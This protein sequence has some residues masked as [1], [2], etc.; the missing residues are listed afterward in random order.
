[1]AI[2]AAFLIMFMMFYFWYR[3]VKIRNRKNTQPLQWETCQF[4]MHSDVYGTMNIGNRKIPVYQ[5]GIMHHGDIRMHIAVQK[6]GITLLDIRLKEES[7]MAQ[8]PVHIAIM[9]DKMD[10]MVGLL[11]CFYS[12]G[13]I[14]K[15]EYDWSNLHVKN[16][17]QLNRM[18]GHGWITPNSEGAYIWKKTIS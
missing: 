1:M 13:N 3:Y 15:E 6:N 12:E 7:L 2:D 4:E 18:I 11:D 8:V 10:Y 16:I 14:R 9:E 5:P 17:R